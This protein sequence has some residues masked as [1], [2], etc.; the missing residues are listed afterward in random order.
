MKFIKLILAG[1]LAS[2]G[3]CGGGDQPEPL[4]V[5][6][7]RLDALQIATWPVKQYVVRTT[8]EW[9]AVWEEP[10]SIG[11]PRGPVPVVDFDK[12]A[13]VGVSMGWAPAPCGLITIKRIWRVNSDYTVEY[14]GT[15]VAGSRFCVGAA[16]RGER[17]VLARPR[18]GPAKRLYEAGFRSVEQV[19]ASGPPTLAQVKELAWQR[20]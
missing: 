8:A 18:L 17:A 12:T 19:C 3:A 11:N 5:P 7:V 16:T 9:A 20:Q 2:L 10:V 14:G 4:P 15:P 6:V 1:L 13:V